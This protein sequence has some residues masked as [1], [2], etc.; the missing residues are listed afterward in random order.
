MNYI[1]CAVKICQRWGLHQY[2]QTANI[3]LEGMAI[4]IV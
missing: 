1:L 3:T 4:Y 2:S